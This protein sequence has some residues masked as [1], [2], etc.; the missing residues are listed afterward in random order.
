MNDENRAMPYFEY[1][2]NFLLAP[3]G[4]WAQE[5]IRKRYGIDLS[6][7]ATRL[8]ALLKVAELEGWDTYE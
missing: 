3:C 4:D 6:A 1:M 7:S 5:T 2:R 8:E